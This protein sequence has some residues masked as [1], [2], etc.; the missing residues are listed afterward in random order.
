MVP[1]GDICSTDEG[2]ASKTKT[3]NLGFSDNRVATSEPAVPP[4][5]T[6]TADQICALD[7]PTRRR[8]SYNNK[9]KRRPLG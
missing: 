5:T 1:W 4:A 8:T 7:D 9:V 6:D 2:P 3:L